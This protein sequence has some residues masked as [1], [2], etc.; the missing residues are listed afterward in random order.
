VRILAVQIQDHPGFGNLEVDFS[1]DDGRAARIVVVAGENGCGKT[2]IL[3]AICNALAPS[4]LLQNLSR[5]LAPGRYR[6]L[7]ETDGPNL[8]TTFNGA[9]LK[10]LLF[11]RL[12]RLRL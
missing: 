10:L 2:A 12:A 1:G 4:S 5:K 8:S 11:N 3:E 9:S 6:V 7:V